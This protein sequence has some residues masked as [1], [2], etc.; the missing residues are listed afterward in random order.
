VATVQRHPA[1]T[2]G[3][4]P[5][6]APVLL[7]T[8]QFYFRDGV[9]SELRRSDGLGPSFAVASGVIDLAFEY[10]GEAQ[11]PSMP[12]AAAGVGNCLYDAAGAPLSAM[13][14]LPGAVGSL[15]SLDL[16][17]FADGP[18]CGTGPTPF[19]AD[20]LRVRAVRMTARLHTLNAALRGAGA[21]FGVPGSARESALLVPDVMLRA[22][23]TPPNLVRAARP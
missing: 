8:S 17:M 21:W 11:P 23:V 7:A 22:D 14:V 1:G 3:S 18:W 16:S 20:L 19:D 2:G 12:V 10:F 5:R 13:P 15:V 4:Y 6:G 9:A